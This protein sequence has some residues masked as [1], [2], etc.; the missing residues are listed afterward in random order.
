MQ[1]L[2]VF[3]AVMMSV[4]A[5]SKRTER[6]HESYARF[7]QMLGQ[8]KGTVTMRATPTGPDVTFHS[9]MTVSGILGGRFI[10]KDM[11]VDLKGA[12]MPATISRG[13]Y[14]YDP[15]TR[16][17]LSFVMNNQGNNG[18]HTLY[19]TPDGK[20]VGTL[21]QRS[22]RGPVTSMSATEY[23]EDRSQSVVQRSVAGAPF[24]T[25]FTSASER[26]E[27]AYSASDDTAGDAPAQPAQEMAVFRRLEGRWALRGKMSLLPDSSPVEVSFQLEASPILHGHASM[28]T[29]VVRPTERSLDSHRIV[30]YFCW[31]KDA[32]CY[33]CLTLASSGVWY[34]SE[35]RLVGGKALVFS[36]SKRVDGVPVAF[37][38]VLSWT[39]NPGKAQ[40][41]TQCLPGTAAVAIPLQVEMTRIAD[42]K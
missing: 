15:N 4:G 13:V 24:N 27:M 18:C 3:V 40:V 42:P 6:V 5:S 14:A 30:N 25:L 23:G 16:S 8:W 31:S 9:L 19:W 33:T 10:Q 28:W 29:A 34:F 41:T 22:Q 11:R 2:P 7:E 39:A 36:G 12:K 37:R 1:V 21:T 26:C 35:G 38:T 20:A 32:D 17:F